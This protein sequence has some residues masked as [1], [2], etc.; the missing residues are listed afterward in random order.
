MRTQ[1]LITNTMLAVLYLF[2]SSPLSMARADGIRVC[3]EVADPSGDGSVIL[4]N[5]RAEDGQVGPAYLDTFAWNNWTFPGW[6]YFGGPGRTIFGPGL[7]IGSHEVGEDMTFVSGTGGVWSDYGISMYNGST[8]ESV[9]R[10]RRTY[11]WYTPSG[12]LLHSWSLISTFNEPLLPGER[13][14]IFSG[15]DTA[16]RLGYV[17]PEQVYF[18]IQFDQFTNYDV[19]NIGVLT[20]GPITDGSSTNFARDFTTGQDIDLGSEYS[21]MVFYLR[22]RPIPAP[23]AASLFAATSLLAL[24]R[25]RTTKAEY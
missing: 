22:T 10:W 17:L 4:H 19:N 23:S 16:Y 11:R 20:G 8:N 24:R 21:N 7:V 14:I 9:T 6:P 15:P 13:A 3:R 5:L 18:T 12:Q 25:R 2:L 1:S